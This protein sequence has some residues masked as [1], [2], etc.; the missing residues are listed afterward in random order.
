[1]PRRRRGWIYRV[2]ES[3]FYTKEA[4]PSLAKLIELEL[5]VADKALNKAID[6][7]LEVPWQVKSYLRRGWWKMG[8]LSR[9][10]ND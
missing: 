2:G 10:L 8:Q 7:G 4:I 1:M 5:A 3:S 6:E 9:M